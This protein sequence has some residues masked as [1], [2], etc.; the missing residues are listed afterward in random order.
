[1]VKGKWQAH[2][3]YPMS[4]I[5]DYLDMFH[6]ATKADVPFRAQGAENGIAMAEDATSSLTKVLHS[7]DHP[8]FSA[9]AW[10]VLDQAY[11]AWDGTANHAVLPSHPRA[12]P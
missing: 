6:A 4:V 11:E 10:D 9:Q 2:H 12:R 5:D 1:M 7:G 8:A 3:L